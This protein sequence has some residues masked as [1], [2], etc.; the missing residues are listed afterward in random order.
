MEYLSQ[1]RKAIVPL[2][3]TGALA[4]LAMVGVTEDMTVGEAVTLL[5]TSLL[6]WIVP[7][8]KA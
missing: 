2:L 4:V 7:N 6:V 3:V 1:I 5:I 8:K